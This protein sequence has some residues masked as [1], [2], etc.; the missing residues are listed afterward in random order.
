[1]LRYASGAVL[2]GSHVREALEAASAILVAEGY[3]AITIVDGDREYEKQVQ[4]FLSRYCLHHELNGRR[5]YDIR[6][7]EGRQYFRH[8]PA[9]TVAAPS[10]TAPHVAKIAADLGAPYNNRYTAA[11]ARL[12]QIAPGLGLDWTG[13][14]FGEDWHWETV[15]GVGLVG[16]PSSG[17]ATPFN[18]EEDDM[19]TEEDR[20]RLERAASDAAWAKARLGGSATGASITDQLRTLRDR[21]ISVRS[22]VQWLR[23]RVGGSTKEGQPTLTELSRRTR[24]AAL[25]AARKVNPDATESDL[26]A[27]LAGE[28]PEDQG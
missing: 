1:M 16:A 14:H 20:K 10:R 12:Q 25:E 3:P 18:P 22:A 19:F 26:I 4:V 15:R 6:W 2:H 23:E 27:V 11:H 9:G 7:W 5:V 8:S 21:V 28:E 13:R 17:G 24:D